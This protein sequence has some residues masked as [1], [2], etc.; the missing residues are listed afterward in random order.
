[1]YSMIKTFHYSFADLVIKDSL[2]YL[3]DV[4][5]LLYLDAHTGNVIIMCINVH[6]T[7]ILIPL[8]YCSYGPQ[9]DS[10]HASSLNIF[11]ATSSSAV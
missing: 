3:Q 10:N 4:M 5:F 8:R 2:P 11:I 7:L 9:S 1:M 6:K